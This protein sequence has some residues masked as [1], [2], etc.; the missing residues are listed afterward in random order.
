MTNSH[1]RRNPAL[2]SAL[3]LTLL[4]GMTTPVWANDTLTG[5]ITV[6][7]STNSIGLAGQAV[8]AVSDDPGIR[9]AA[10]TVAQVADTVGT[11][12]AVAETTVAGAA[13][14][15]GSGATIMK[16]LAIAGG[17]AAMAGATGFTAAKVMNE[18]IYSNC[19]NQAACDAAQYGTYGGAAVGTVASAAAVVVVG[20][21]PAG[22]AAIGS[23]VGGGMVAG[24]ATVVAAPVVAA[25]L[26]GGALYWL[27]SD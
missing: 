12:V 7:R 19:D 15:T 11:G 2:C 3:A 27:F 1:T 21:G 14:A 4:A 10:G 8:A 17:P 26:L 5:I 13:I 24:V 6:S 9:E 18:T 25:A 20:A 22:L 23:V 16:T